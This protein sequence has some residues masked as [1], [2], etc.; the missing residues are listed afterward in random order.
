MSAPRPGSNVIDEPPKEV[1]MTRAITRWEPFFD[2]LF[3]DLYDGGRW[4]SVDVIRDDG[5]MV[6]RAEV[7]G[8]KPEEVELKVEGGLL[9]ISG[10]HEEATEKEEAEYVHR[11]RRYGAFR[12][13]LALPEGI[14]PKKIRATM[15]DGLLEVE[16]PVRDESTA[17]A[18]TITPVAKG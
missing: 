1:L 12:R 17:E 4:P 9:T 7:P 11:E 15:H 6:V 13:T 8:M 18:V 16:I 3:T 10:S 14:D 5:H 2:R